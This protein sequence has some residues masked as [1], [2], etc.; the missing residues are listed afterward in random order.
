MS[1][2]LRIVRQ[3]F[4]RPDFVSFVPTSEVFLSRHHPETLPEDARPLFVEIQALERPRRHMIAFMR[5]LN[6]SALKMQMARHWSADVIEAHT[7]V[8]SRNPS[9]R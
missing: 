8:T 9:P 2:R 1:E 6:V 4:A 5:G 7:G 3:L